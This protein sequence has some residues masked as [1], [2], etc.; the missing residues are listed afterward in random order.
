[1]TM[2]NQYTAKWDSAM[3]PTALRMGQLVRIAHEPDAREYDGFRRCMTAAGK[4]WEFLRSC[5]PRTHADVYRV[6]PLVAD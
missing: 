4:D 1:M 6:I 2:I 5:G 3:N